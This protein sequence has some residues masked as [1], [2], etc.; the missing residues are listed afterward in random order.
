MLFQRRIVPLSCI[1]KV[2]ARHLWILAPHSYAA[3]W[4]QLRIGGF[5]IDPSSRLL[6]SIAIPTSHL[7]IPTPHFFS[8][9]HQ[10]FKVRLLASSVP[11]LCSIVFPASHRWI[12]TPHS[13]ATYWFQ[14]HSGG[15]QRPALLQHRGSSA[16]LVDSD[17]P[18][19]F[20]ATL[21]DSSASFLCSIVVPASGVA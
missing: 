2:T 15:F 10:A 3:L 11:F 14:R 20:Q 18:F 17:A 13:Y 6:C 4:L 8:T 1:M 16:T 9:Q 21:V 19:G 12:A 5:P 7:W